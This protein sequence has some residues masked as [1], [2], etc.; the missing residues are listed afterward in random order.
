MTTVDVLG[1]HGNGSIA[2]PSLRH[3]DL[4]EFFVSLERIRKTS[5]LKISYLNSHRSWLFWYIV[6]DNLESDKSVF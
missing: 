3:L 1:A 4:N 5:E 6:S 2:G